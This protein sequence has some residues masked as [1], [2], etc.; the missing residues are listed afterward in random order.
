MGD[1]P[2]GWKRRA[3]VSALANNNPIPVTLVQ[4]LEGVALRCGNCGRVE[5]SLRRKKR[6]SGNYTWYTHCRACDEEQRLGGEL[7]ARNRL[8][9]I[10]PQLPRRVL[11]GS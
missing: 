3:T 9:E 10:D 11:G 1:Q 8:S 4:E 2:I 5:A 6:F 7:G